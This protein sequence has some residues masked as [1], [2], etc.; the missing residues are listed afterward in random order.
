MND[1]VCVG[2]PHWLDAM[3]GHAMCSDVGAVGARLIH[4]GG[5]VQHAGVIC[6]HGVAGHLYKGLPAGHPGNGWL[7]LVT[8]EASAVTGACML[9]SRKNFDRVGGFDAEMF[10]LNYSDTD[11][12]L[13]LRK[14]DLRNVVE[15]ATDLLHPE[16][17]S[18]TDPGDMANL[19]R[20]LQEDNVRFAKRW[21][22]PD[23]VPGTLCCRL[24]CRREAWA[25]PGS[26]A[27][28]WPGTGD[29]SGPMLRA[30]CWSTIVLGG[31]AR[32]RRACGG[33]RSAWLPT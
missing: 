13:R 29:P 22:G 19:V 20:R 9:V 8:H 28:C 6:H 4:P 21:P 31:K 5:F 30:C 2:T 16:G 11:F 1:D 17:T 23:P 24:A 25:S 14:L 27:T 26:T 3:M 32:R 33:A 15:A 7:S 10:P 18:R 12:C